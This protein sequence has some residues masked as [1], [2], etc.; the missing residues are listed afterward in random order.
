MANLFESRAIKDM[1]LANGFF[2]SATWEGMAGEDGSVTPRLIGIMGQM[3][4]VGEKQVV[5]PGSGIS[6]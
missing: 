2:R 4:P 3:A 5:W 1:T 6:K